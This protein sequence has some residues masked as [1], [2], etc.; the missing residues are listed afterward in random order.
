MRKFTACTYVPKPE[1][2]FQVCFLSI[3]LGY[4][5]KY[6]ITKFICNNQRLVNLNINTKA[7]GLGARFIETAVPVITELLDDIFSMSFAVVN[8]R[9][10]LQCIEINLLHREACLLI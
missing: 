8:Y 5:N 9:F 3:V 4:Q 7:V 6:I 1:T 10:A 2:L